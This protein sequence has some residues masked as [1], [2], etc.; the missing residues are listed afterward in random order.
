MGSSASETDVA[1]DSTMGPV[2]A[3][4]VG[5]PKNL[6]DVLKKHADLKAGAEAVAIKRGR[7][8][9]PN[10]SKPGGTP[11]PA[12][13]AGGGADLPSNLFTPDSVRP[14]VE[15]PFA[16]GNV[17][18]RTEQFTLDPRES[19]TLAVQGALVANLYAPGWN[20]KAVALAALALGF[21]S[22]SSKKFLQYLGERA[23]KKK[24]EMTDSK[25]GQNGGN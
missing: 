1:A 5:D 12:A 4:G 21:A 9:P 23:E 3:G 13:S 15:L 22:I 19:D 6:A 20:P 18:F 17:W 11:K 2:D 7:G 14:F 8:R 10:A 25:G 16:L 24:K